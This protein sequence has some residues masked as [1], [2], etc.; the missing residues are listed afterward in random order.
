[1]GDQ[2]L[3]KALL[4]EGPFAA[5]VL[6]L[7]ASI[8]YF[9]RGLWDWIKGRHERERIQSKDRRDTI[10]ELKA[11]LRAAEDNADRQAGWRR[12]Y[13]EVL[14]RTRLE[15]HRETDKDFKDM[16]KPPEPPPST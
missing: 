14:H 10:T 2:D 3:L 7:V 9:L 13:E 11:E 15:W 16:P 1:M 4:S 6:M 8:G 12:A 5:F